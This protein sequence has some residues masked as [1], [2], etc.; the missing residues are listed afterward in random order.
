MDSV[1]TGAERRSLE[2]R[3]AERLISPLRVGL[4]LFCLHGIWVFT[5][6]WFEGFHPTDFV[7]FHGAGNLFA[8]GRSDS[9]YDTEAFQ[10]FL[11]AEYGSAFSGGS[12]A[13]FLN[14]PPF[15]WFAQVLGFLPLTPSLIAFS[16]VNIVLAV[17]AYRHLELPAKALP[18]LLLSPMMTM[19]VGLG[20]TGSLA[21]IATVAVHCNMVR[22][23][24]LAAGIAAGAFILK[25]PLAVGYG[26]LWLIRARRSAGMIAIALLT[27][28]V[29]SIPT[30][31]TGTG[32]WR[33]FISNSVERTSVDQQIFGRSFSFAEFAKPFW[34]Q[35]PTTVTLVMW[36]IGLGLGVATLITVD[37]RF[38]GDVEV[39][40]AAASVV[41][42]LFSPHVLLYD[43][44]L[45]VIPVAVAYRRGVLNHERV[46]ALTLILSVGVIFRF[47]P[48]ASLL[49]PISLEFPAV[50]LA[51][52][53]IG[54]WLLSATT[55]MA[56]DSGLAVGADAAAVDREREDLAVGE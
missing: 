34:H 18:L 43:S 19:N 15:G 35:A 32:Q 31:L 47:L 42:V 50:V 3:R 36:A 45:L 51:S 26:L 10:A 41:T 49:G 39:L 17:A 56:A 21:L 53:L 12:L 22:G 54:K 1:S 11:T 8:D 24:T 40:S 14:P 7:V 30:L 48:I 9:A 37:R 55:A 16:I 25:P 5:G 13:Q 20:Q 4:A 28:G 27:G 29:L 38:G 33:S 23:R 52:V 2:S 6:V 46:G 44:L